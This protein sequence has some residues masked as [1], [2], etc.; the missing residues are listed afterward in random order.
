MNKKLFLLGAL[1][2]VLAGVVLTFVVLFIIGK[3][4]QN[5][6]KNGNDQI[7]YLESPV[8]YENKAETSFK[9]LQV[10]GDAAL[11]MERSSDDYDFYLGNTVLLLG[12]NF[13]S[14]QIVTVRNPQRIGTYSYVTRNDISRTVPVISG[15]LVE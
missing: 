14:D 3:T 7:Q 9:V 15:T 10:L 2:G 5:S 11:A 12:E 6:G 8:S 13:Y 4:S 1:V